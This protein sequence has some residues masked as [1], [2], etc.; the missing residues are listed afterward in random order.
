MMAGIRKSPCVTPCGFLTKSCFS[1]LRCGHWCTQGG[2]LL[3]GRLY[4]SW[5]CW[6]DSPSVLNG[7]CCENDMVTVHTF[8]WQTRR[9]PLV[10][11]TPWGTEENTTWF[12][13]LQSSRPPGKGRDHWYCLLSIKTY[14]E[15][16]KFAHGQGCI[17]PGKDY[18]PILTRS[19]S[20]FLKKKRLSFFIVSYL[21]K[22]K[23]YVVKFNLETQ[24]STG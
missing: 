9:E 11:A 16:S 20:Y 7:N 1:L 24:W 23:D 21:C 15:T 13:R 18:I 14:S 6:W 12:L 19:L 22:L 2:W 10:C 17:L 4:L 5:W 3:R 8:I